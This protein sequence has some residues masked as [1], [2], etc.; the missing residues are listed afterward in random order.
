MRQLVLSTL[1]V[2]LVAVLS[3][4]EVGGHIARNTTWSP[5]H[6]PYIVIS[7][8]YIDNGATLT[9]LPGTEVRVLGAEKSNIFNFMWSGNTQPEAKMII[10]NGRINAIGTPEL[11]ITFDKYQDDNAYRWGSI[12]MSPA[13]QISSFEYCE[14]RHAFFCDYVPGEWSL[15]AIDFD[16]G[17]INVRSCTFENNLNA[18]R[19]KFLQSDILLYDCKFISVNDT[20]PSPFGVN[21]F[22]G[23]SA[24]PDPE[25]SSFRKRAMTVNNTATM[26]IPMTAA[27]V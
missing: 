24:A 11:P 10:V 3:G 8:L 27:F 18:I 16:N 1:L 9:I 19:T 7:F 21:G 4:T 25:P 22:L 6:N 5:E 26:M 17:F 13:A 23:F 20:Y 2:L 12:Y 15:A 14:F